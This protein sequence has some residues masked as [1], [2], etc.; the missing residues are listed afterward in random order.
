MR[1]IR[2]IRKV[3]NSLYKIIF[4]DKI[5]IKDLRRQNK[6]LEFQLAYM[7][8]HCEI[9][10]IKPANGWLREYQLKELDFAIEIIELF[11]KFDIHPFFDGGCLIGACRHKGFVP[12]DDDVDI[13][14]LRIDFDKI[15]SIAKANYV[16]CE[17]S[18]EYNSFD[19]FCDTSITANK[20][21]LVFIRTPYCIHIYKG[22]SLKD[23]VN[24]ELFVYDYVKD[25]ITE[26]E[27]VNYLESY[28]QK[29]NL[30]LPWTELYSFY[31]KELDSDRYLTRT[32]TSRLSNG[33]GNFALTQMKFFGFFS[34]TDFFPLKKMEFEGRLIPTPCNPEAKLDKSY[35]DFRSWPKD[36]GICHSLEIINKYFDSNNE[37]LSFEEI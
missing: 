13:S 3:L 6:R 35:T 4:N 17:F 36:V 31:D 33:Y 32:P 1:I 11:E 20:N 10:K 2:G 29:I 34:I 26:T 7:K 22:E 23:S 18:H 25:G 12:W 37:T 28:K 14:V 9:S 5:Q 15:I 24:C 16:W 30:S 21:K 19:E 27:F 8:R